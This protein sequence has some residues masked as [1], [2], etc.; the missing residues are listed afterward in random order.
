MMS[1]KQITKETSVYRLFCVSYFLRYFGIGMYITIFNI[2]LIS[3]NF[4]GSF[5]GIFLSVGNLSMAVFSIPL[6]NLID[7]ISKRKALLCL[8]LIA[9]VCFF[10]QATI[11]SEGLLLVI[12]AIYGVAFIGLI[13]TTGPL[14]YGL[15]TIEK[16]K[17]FIMTTK[18]ISLISGTLG[19]I[20]CG[21]LSLA[22]YNNQGILYIASFVLLSSVIPIVF[23]P[24]IISIAK[25]MPSPEETPLVKSIKE[26]EE[27]RKNK[28]NKAL[29]SASIIVFSFLGFAP[30]IQ[31]FVNLYFSNRYNLTDSN[32]SFIVAT[33]TLLIGVIVM[34]NSK[35]KASNAKNIKVNFIIFGLSIFLFNILLMLFDNIVIHIVGIFLILGLFQIYY[36]LTYDM[37]LSSTKNSIHGKISGFINMS[38]NL[39]ETLGIYISSI[40]IIGLDFDLVF[41]ISA[42][43]SLL[44]IMA[45]LYVIKV[46]GKIYG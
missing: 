45:T 17:N 35:L 30:L 28:T 42:I 13:N 34:M 18:S 39:S 10:L 8:T 43:S 16:E 14:L 15:K 25:E 33:V 4:S 24:K 26:T 21:V 31:N 29:I 27:I 36:S 46:G 11:L 20:I 22:G 9:S 2:Y 12:S 7:K 44:V 3:M 37:I 1:N 40:L 19:A 41:I 32:T 23:M 6:G 5:L 38:S